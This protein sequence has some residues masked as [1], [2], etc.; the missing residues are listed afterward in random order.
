MKR[1]MFVFAWIMLTF[2]ILA[3]L[4]IAYAQ[5]QP[6]KPDILSFTSDLASV[7]P[8]EAESGKKN[9]VLAWEVAHWSDE[10][11][12][13]LQ[14][15]VL[16][17]WR[18]ALPAG[19]V[20]AE[21]GFYTTTVPHTLDFQ[22]PTWRLLVLDGEGQIVDEAILNLPYMVDE[23]LTTQILSF[24]PLGSAVEVNELVRRTARLSVSWQIRGRTP[25]ANLRFEQTT[26]DGQVVSV[27][28]PRQFE[29]VRSNSTGVVAPRY[30]NDNRRIWV[31]LQVYDITTGEIYAERVIEVPVVGVINR[32]VAAQ[33]SSATLLPT[34]TAQGPC[35]EQ[36]FFQTPDA[37]YM[38]SGGGALN[39]IAFNLCPSTGVG[40]SKAIIQVF[41]QGYMLY[42]ADTNTVYVL[43]NN[44]FAVSLPNEYVEGEPLNYP[45][46]PPNRLL[47]PEG[48]WGKAWIEHY[49]ITQFLGWAM[50][51]AVE[52]TMRFQ[53]T[54]SGTPTGT[55]MTISDDGGRIFITFGVYG[56]TPPM[57]AYINQY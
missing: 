40:S 56:G 15:Y 2:S 7:T 27:E 11:H 23:N 51:P 49:D 34:W 3:G 18:D 10:Y 29:W 22:S 36:F 5:G 14:V 19:K 6:A 17:E 20:L 43:S 25:N 52:Y 48:V 37:L 46:T 45:D 57:W 42:R 44:A 24:A 9:T 30:L 32:P 53:E 33:P 28:P 35:T 50:F 38:F 47:A 41:E 31:R 39:G 13:N 26:P 4:S 55:V 12:L 21:S 1:L 54:Y 8:N 16:Q